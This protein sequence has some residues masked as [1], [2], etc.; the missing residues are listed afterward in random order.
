MKKGKN[1]INTGK[2]LADYIQSYKINKTELGNAINRR[3]ISILNY[4][5]NSSIQTGILIEICYALKH[6]FFKEIADQL[7][8]D[9]TTKNKKDKSLVSEKDQ[10]IAQLLEENKVL[11]I[12]NDLLMKL[13]S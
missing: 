1:N 6:N 11:K 4:T 12:Q 10:L 7:P 2:I 8:E 9:F 5:R 13:R 3:G